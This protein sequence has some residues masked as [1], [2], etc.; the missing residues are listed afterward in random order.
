M[1]PAAFPTTVLSRCCINNNVD[2]R[3]LRTRDSVVK[4]L[5]K[6]QIL[7][8]VAIAALTQI[9]SK[10]IEHFFNKLKKDKEDDKEDTKRAKEGK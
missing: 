5:G 8:A 9:C 4:F 6:K 1:T 7:E 3:K 10:I 2:N